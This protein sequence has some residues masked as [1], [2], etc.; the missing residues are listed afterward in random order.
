[1]FLTD[2]YLDRTALH[3]SLSLDRVDATHRSADDNPVVSEARAHLEQYGIASSH[4]RLAHVRAVG[5]GE[6][7]DQSCAM[8]ERECCLLDT[9]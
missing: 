9:H 5:T 3:L 8:S 7:D 6:S 4:C 1:M 2:V